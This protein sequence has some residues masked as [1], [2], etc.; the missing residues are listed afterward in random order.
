MSLPKWVEEVSKEKGANRADFTPRLIQA[1]GIMWGVLESI[2]DLDSDGSSAIEVCQQEAE[3][4]MR[5]IE[6]L[7]E[8]P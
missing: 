4:A 6:D 8:N 2:M 7:G 1:V 5:E 3:E